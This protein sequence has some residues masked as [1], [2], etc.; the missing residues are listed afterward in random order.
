MHLK[1]FIRTVISQKNAAKCAATL[2]GI[3]FFSFE[4]ALTFYQKN[5]GYLN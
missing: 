4:F 1:I 5:A 3:Q 2:A